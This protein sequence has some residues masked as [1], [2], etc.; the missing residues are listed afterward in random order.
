M[1]GVVQG[2]E[3]SDPLL[4]ILDTVTLAAFLL[5]VLLSVLIG[6]STAVHSY[7]E[8]EQKMTE[9]KSQTPQKTALRESINGVANMAPSNV[10]IA[11]LSIEGISKLSPTNSVP[12]PAAAPATPSTPAGEKK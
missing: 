6:I 7:Q 4:V 8:K 3:T 10:S 2:S 12:T 9:E 1:E 11:K 5:G